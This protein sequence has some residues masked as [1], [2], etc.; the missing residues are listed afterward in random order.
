MDQFSA[1]LPEGL[2]I[3]KIHHVAVIVRDMEAS[4]GLYRDKMGLDVDAVMDM[5]YDHVIIGFLP[6]GEVKIEV[7]Q[8][9]DNST[10]SARFLESKGE[11]FHHICFE[12]PDIQAALDKLAGKGLTLIDTI[13]RKGG[14]G[15]VA[16]IH[17]K[18]CHGV[19]VELIEAPG[20]PAWAKLEY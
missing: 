16:F 9:T 7:V 8:P 3:R 14:E 6:V 13:P 20:G 4:L 5:A 19:L 15:P 12:V 17:P 11:G 1:A 10:G 18:S 2:G